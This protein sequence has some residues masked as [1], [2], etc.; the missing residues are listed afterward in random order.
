MDL[1]LNSPSRLLPKIQSSALPDYKKPGQPP[2]FAT[3]III[4]CLQTW[5]ANL[6]KE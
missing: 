6:N 4:S 5:A 1:N 3:A 2:L